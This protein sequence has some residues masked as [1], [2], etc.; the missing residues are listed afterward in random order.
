M[1]RTLLS[2]LFFSFIPV[3][4]FS[5]YRSFINLWDLI[6]EITIFADIQCMVV[7]ECYI[8]SIRSTMFFPILWKRHCRQFAVK[9]AHCTLFTWYSIKC[10]QIQWKLIFPHLICMWEKAHIRS[11]CPPLDKK[12]HT[13][14]ISTT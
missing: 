5:V 2:M 14:P 1:W 6:F 3:E 7:I 10:R 8:F 11:V 12:T 4:L 13:T 9:H